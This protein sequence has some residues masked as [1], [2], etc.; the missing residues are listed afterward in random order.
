MGSI[1]QCFWID[2]T[3]RTER[4]LRRFAWS[5]TPDGV[6]PGKYGYHNGFTPFPEGHCTF[7]AENGT[8]K[9]LDAFEIPPHDDP[10]WP[11]KC[12]ECAYEFKPD[13][14]WQ[15]FREVVY[16]RKDTGAE[17]TNRNCPPGAMYDAVWYPEKGPDGRAIIVALPPDGGDDWWHVDGYAKGGGKWTRTG[18]PPNISVTPSILTPRYHGF[19]QGGVLREC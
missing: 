16:V 10:R 4:R 14:E 9:W 17:M 7:D 1:I 8:W 19:L 18:E 5:N 12:A 3:N 11:T 13:D 2:P 15:L 6:C